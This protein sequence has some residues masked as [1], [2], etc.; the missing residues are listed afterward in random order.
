MGE[1]VK[2]LY[3]QAGSSTA[4]TICL[5]ERRLSAAQA[6]LLLKVKIGKY[7]N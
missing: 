7:R 2:V 4:E 6:A 1:Y 3:W 5:A